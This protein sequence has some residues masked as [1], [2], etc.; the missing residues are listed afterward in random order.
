MLR[1]ERIE[2]SPADRPAPELEELVVRIRPSIT[3]YVSNR[4]RNR[5]HQ[6]EIVSR[7]FEALARS[8]SSFRGDCPA[9][10][11]AIRIAA[12][13]VK[14]YYER[15]LAK[16]SR[17]ISLDIWCEEFCLQHTAGVSGPHLE[18][19]LRDEVD[20][21]LKEMQKACSEIECAVV[22]LVYQGNTMDEIGSLLDLKAATVRSHFLRGRE[23]LLAHLLVE[24]PDLLGGLDA[25]TAAVKRLETDP[26]EALS[27]EEAEA[28]RLR[29]GPATVLRKAMLKLAPYLGVIAWLVTGRVR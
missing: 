6:E 8:W 29:K 14:N 7:V 24:A 11:F 1:P 4:V 28:I 18:V 26:G 27:R 9:D 20:S 23:R 13:A 17:Q 22:E 3:G 10:A 19:H 15:D 21:L 2:D 16:Q 12:N 5:D 25:V